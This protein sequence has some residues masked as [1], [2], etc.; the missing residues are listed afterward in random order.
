MLSIHRAVMFS[1]AAILFATSSASATEL[2]AG[3]W[4]FWNSSNGVKPNKAAAG[5]KCLTKQDLENPIVLLGQLPSDS[6]C[7]AAVIRKT[8]E[9]QL[10]YELSCDAGLVV[11]GGSTKLVSSQKFVSAYRL[12]GQTQ[13]FAYIHG[14]RGGVCTK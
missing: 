14:E 9:S 2:E 1:F 6:P 3:F 10:Q 12:A 11:G 5:G 13:S 7:K 4:K 8:S